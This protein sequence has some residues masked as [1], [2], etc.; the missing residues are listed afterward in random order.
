M[1]IAPVTEFRFTR[2]ILITDIKTANIAN[3][4]INHNDLAVIAIV[5]PKVGDGMFRAKIALSLSADIS[6]PPP[7]FSRGTH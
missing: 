2:N 3:V 1:C 5:K 6:E 7:P 4:I